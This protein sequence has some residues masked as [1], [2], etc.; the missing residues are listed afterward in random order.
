[1]NEIQN[2]FQETGWPYQMY[3]G[4][5]TFVLGNREYDIL[6]EGSYGYA[7]YYAGGAHPLEQDM[8]VADVIDWLEDGA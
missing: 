4:I 7:I 3:D 8:T 2:W 6:N 5:L 1:M